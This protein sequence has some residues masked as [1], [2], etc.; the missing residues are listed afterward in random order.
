M[1]KLSIY[2]LQKQRSQKLR[3][4]AIKFARSREESFDF[5]ALILLPQHRVVHTL[6]LVPT[7]AN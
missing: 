4:L 5:R 1:I 3:V 7:S 2:L 6:N